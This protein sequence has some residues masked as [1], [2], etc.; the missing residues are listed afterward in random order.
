MHNEIGFSEE[1]AYFDEVIL[2]YSAKENFTIFEVFKFIF[3]LI[4]QIE[5]F[6]NFFLWNGY[7]HQYLVIINIPLEGVSFMKFFG[8]FEF[9]LKKCI[10]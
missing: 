7:Q 6:F 2:F 9:F 8:S 10:F 5:I 3:L 1:T 4:N